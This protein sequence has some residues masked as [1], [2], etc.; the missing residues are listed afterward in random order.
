MSKHGIEKPELGEQANAIAAYLRKEMK[1]T[2]TG[3]AEAPKDTCE[4]TLP[5]GLTVKHVSQLQAY[6]SDLIA[7]T[8]LV[9]GDEGA[10]F[11][12]KNKSITDVSAEIKVGKNTVGVTYSREKQV[13]AP[14]NAEPTTKYGVTKAFYEAHAAGHNRGGLKKVREYNSAVAEAA[15]SS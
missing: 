7:A 4:K 1:L 15:A 8:A 11:L 2:S 10:K 13:R 14:G 5:E 3:V 9:L 12:A 6:E